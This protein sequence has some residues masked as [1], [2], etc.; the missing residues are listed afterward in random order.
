MTP[1]QLFHDLLG[2]GQQWRVVKCEYAP[3]Q[4]EVSAERDGVV[5]LWVEETPALWSG[6]SVAARQLVRCY[7]HVEEELVWRHLN[8][9]EHS[10][11][12][13]C[14]LP[15]GQRTTDGKVY[16][17]TPPWEGLAKH[18]TKGFEAM[19]LLLL[20]QMPVSAVAR[21]VGETDK[22]LWRML[23]SH[24]AAAWP[25]ADWSGV[26]G[27]GCDE[28]SARK[29]HRYVSVFCDLIGKR[30]LF[31]TPGKDKSTWEAFVEALSAHNGHRRAIKEVSIDMSPAY[32]AG[33]AENIGGHAIIV[34]DK[35]HVIMHANEAVDETRRIELAR[36]NKPERAQLKDSRWVL[37][38]NPENHTP[39]QAERYAGL[40]TSNLLSVKAHQMR[41]ILQAIYAI[42]DA[43]VARRK[44]RAWCRW[45]R[46]IA[47]KHQA[48]LLAAMV[49]TSRMIE[50]HLDGVMAHWI[51]RTTNAFME[52]L[53]SVFSAV[54]RKARGFR[55]TENLIAMLYFTAGHLDL[56]ATH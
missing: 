38:K 19:T 25:K 47:S 53:N 7:D 40:L 12:I 39:K 16:R 42:A 22:R 37:L 5:R 35:F 17:V 24:V 10:C 45:V 20:R 49:K 44:M 51:H 36:L 56:P 48:P 9:F 29:G 21:H 34:F 54:K 1:E 33:V 50:R 43:K 14:R 31:A 2:L 6:E 18:F 28:M 32:I 8:V 26:V 46:W 13:R 3:K 30:V 4:G 23:H 11:E 15:R 41:L 27:V 55:S 52:G